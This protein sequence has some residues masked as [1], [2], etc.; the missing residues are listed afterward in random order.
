M[1]NP[2]NKPI[3]MKFAIIT[4]IV[5]IVL[6]CLLMACGNNSK[7]SQ[8]RSK[9]LVVADTLLEKAFN[10]YDN[11]DFA[12]SIDYTRDA[13][14][15]YSAQHDSASMSDAY[16]LLT[17]CYQRISMTDSA[18]SNGVAGMMIEQRLHDNERL[19]SSYSNLAAIYLSAERPQEAKMFINRSIAVENSLPTPNPSKQA[20]R[21]AIAAEVYLKLGMTDT[22]LNY[23][24]KAYTID[25]TATDTI[26][27]GRRLSVMGDIYS[28]RGQ[29]KQAGE[30]YL[31]AMAC[32]KASGDK[33][34]Q[35][36]TLKNMGSLRDKQGH[37]TEAI[38]C[39]EQSVKLAQECNAKRVL[40]QNYELMAS[41]ASHSQPSQAVKFMKMSSELKDSIYNDATSNM[42]A[43]Y[44]MEFESK[45]KQ[46]TIEEQQHAITKQRLAIIAISIAVILLLLLSGAL[47]IINLLKSKAQRAEKN[48]E[49]MKTLFFTNVTHEFR[50][51]L[52]VILGETEALRTMDLNAA[53][54]SRYNAIINQG[55]HLLD[56]VN[57]LL[58]MSKVETAV[59]SLQ[60]QNGDIS[61]MV[62]M[63]VENMRVAAENRNITI[64]TTFDDSDFNIDFVPEY[65]HSIVTNL[66]GNSLKFTPSGGRVDIAMTSNNSIVTLKISDNGC[67]IKAKDL[68]HIFDLFYQ[69]DAEQA[70]LGTGIGLSI[71]K[72]MTETMNGSINV[73]SKEGEGSTFTIKMPTRQPDGDYP[74]WVPK[75][76]SRP[77]EEEIN[78]TDVSSIDHDINELDAGNK[79]IALV[80]EDNH[81]VAT[82]IEHVLERQFNVVH[83]YDGREGVTKAHELVPDIIITD[84]MMPGINGYELCR[85]IRHD[86]LAGHVPII[87]VTAR[88]TRNDRLEALAVGADAFLVKPFNN[89]ELNALA[90]NLLL[91]RKMLRMKYQATVADLPASSEPGH[92]EEASTATM[93]TAGLVAQNN[94]IFIDKVKTIIRENLANNELSSIFIAD[95]MNLSQRQLN[96]K[97]KSTVNIDTTSLIRDVRIAVAK[98]MLINSQDPVSE[99]AERCGFDSASYFSKIFKQHTKLTPTEF[100]KQILS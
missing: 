88:S 31:Q 40:Q 27:M 87:V 5:C 10:C 65:W 51:P 48:A 59:G 98:H 32:H 22:A 84:L 86:E 35:M 25:S 9:E 20:I 45:E 7:N 2:N 15:L 76:L 82:Y 17:A 36:L 70:D 3:G 42:A 60:W 43:Q 83:A 67:G 37:A 68:P 58:N 90:G 100:R 56:L 93:T 63:I 49:Q 18:L 38:A 94:R 55:N 52:T 78:E 96:R 75:I 30:R 1:H 47:F 62:R 16:S 77:F 54:Q 81:D 79:P 74:K 26:H 46:F 23:I 39:L 80:V 24:N 33:Y 73:E 21:Y 95:K 53:N 50:T 11:A 97:I 8:K 69:G 92:H 4:A 14:S 71:V 85:R 34:S 12:Q 66:I 6:P 72:M 19:S 28:A 41:V 61:T 99:I 29:L 64:T 57:Q 13:L 91:N 89:D 44:A